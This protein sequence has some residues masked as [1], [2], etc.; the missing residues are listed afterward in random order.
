MSILLPHNLLLSPIVYPV[1]A[2]LSSFTQYIHHRIPTCTLPFHPLPMSLPP[3][4]IP[5]LPL[6]LE[7]STLKLANFF[8]NSCTKCSNRWVKH[9]YTQVALAIFPRLPKGMDLSS[10]SNLRK[11]IP[12]AEHSPSHQGYPGL[13]CA[14]TMKMQVRECASVSERNMQVSSKVGADHVPVTPRILLKCKRTGRQIT[15]QDVHK[16][17][18]LNSVS[19]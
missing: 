19:I 15:I 2:G 12:S 7:V 10:L 6:L 9:V 13:V 17:Y 3:Y 8:L 5:H 14:F 4:S 18:I 1:H 16:L 11:V